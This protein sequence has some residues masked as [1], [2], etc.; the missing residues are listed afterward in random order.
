M[1]LS[2]YP[3]RVSV[4]FG[5]RQNFTDISE[6][7]VI[8]RHKPKTGFVLNIWKYSSIYYLSDNNIIL[9]N[10]FRPL[11]TSLCFSHIQ[12]F[13]RPYYLLHCS[14]KTQSVRLMT[15]HLPFFEIFFATK[16]HFPMSYRDITLP[17]GGKK[18]DDVARNVILQMSG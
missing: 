8:F 13:N 2:S 16:I 6:F 12:V 10:S 15:P 5:F 9:E 3:L 7:C 14:S 11:C 17:P 18:Q 1:S 4:S